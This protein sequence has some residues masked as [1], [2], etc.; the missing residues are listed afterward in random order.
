M[1]AL[2]WFAVTALGVGGL[3]LGR[4]KRKAPP[5]S[6]SSAAAGCRLSTE[7]LVFLANQAA[8]SRDAGL[9]NATA[10]IFESYGCPAEAAELRKWSP[11]PAP[12]PPPGAPLPQRLKPGAVLELAAGQVYRGAAVLGPLGC[13]VPLGIIRKKLE[14]A[15]FE[16]IRLE[17][18]NPFGAGWAPPEGFL[19]CSRFAEVRYTGAPKKEKAPA[20]V[21]R[22]ER[23]A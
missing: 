23:I 5:P 20:Q 6:S 9:I 7:Q 2:G 19:E 3:L 15:G 18:E 22:L 17:E 14:G 4:A 8:V 13:A 10:A 11:A 12:T 16:V 21:W 1:N